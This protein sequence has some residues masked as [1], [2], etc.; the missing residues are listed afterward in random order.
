MGPGKGATLNLPMPAGCSDAEYRQVLTEYFL[1]AAEAFQP[2][3]VLVSAGFDPHGD[4][5]LASIHLTDEGF[6]WMGRMICSVADRFASGR[7]V[8]IL[9]GGYNLDVL[10]RCVAEHVGILAGVTDGAG[11]GR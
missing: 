8:S 10:Q 7:L 11:P 6:A 3:L 4:D 2:Q 9:E 1:P 5:P